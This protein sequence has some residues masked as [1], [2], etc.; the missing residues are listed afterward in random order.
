MRS[1]ASG[2]DR[3]DR[4]VRLAGHDVDRDVRPEEV[5]LAALDRPARV[6]VAF[7][8]LAHRA[9]L[10]REGGALLEHVGVHGDVDDLREGRMSDL[11]VVALEEVLAAHLPVRLVLGG[12][13]LEETKRAE[14]EAGGR[15][16][17]GQLAEVLG[18][19]RRVGVR[20]D[21]D[22]RPQA[23]TCTGTQP[24]LGLVEAGLALGAR[25]GAER[26]VEAVGPGV[27]RALERLAPPLA[28]ADERA[29][30]A[31][32]VQE[33]AERAFLV[34]HD[35]DR[36]AA[37][38]AGEERARL[39]DLIGAA[40]VLPG[41][42][43]DPLPLEP[44]HVRIRVP[45]ERERAAVGDRR[46]APTLAG[47]RRRLSAAWSTSVSSSRPTSLSGCSSS[48]TVSTRF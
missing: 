12:R 35:D 33:R 37:R 46:H 30:V 36:H 31:A 4:E 27:V 28:L 34:A 25:R 23:S 24:E 20:V 10:R 38:V 45:V 43:E 21:E 44:E 15:D 19:R 5:E 1:A 2:H 42:P 32:D 39:G 6:E 29:A 7:P 11:A 8:G 22:E 9:V 17:L 26:A 41:A 16:E 13:A 47:C 48:S 3:A 40:R 18:E 14:V